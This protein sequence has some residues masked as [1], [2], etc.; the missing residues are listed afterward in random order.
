MIWFLS[1]F[2]SV[3]HSSP[4][5]ATTVRSI[6]VSGMVLCR[7]KDVF[8]SASR[9]VV[10]CEM[11]S[12]SSVSR[13]GADRRITGREGAG[14]GSCVGSRAAESV[15]SEGAAVIV[16]GVVLGTVFDFDIGHA[17]YELLACPGWK[18]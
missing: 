1:A 6:S 11:R 12:A 10:S 2:H 9:D 5:S 16:A 15:L 8:A 14:G 18:Q 4:T 17:P 7:W 3:L 13:I